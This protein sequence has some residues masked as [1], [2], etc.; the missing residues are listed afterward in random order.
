MSQGIAFDKKKV[1]KA[2]KPYFRLG[3]SLR[4]ACEYAGIAH[5]TVANWLMKDEELRTQITAWQN[6]INVLSR[7]KW[8]AAIKKGDA[9]KAVSWLERKERREFARVEGTVE[10][11]YEDFQEIKDE[12]EED[13]DEA[14]E[15]HKK[16]KEATIY[17]QKRKDKKICND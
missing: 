11:P 3:C 17:L 15:E 7:K 9:D 6:E 2:L 1:V 12:I 5:T 13:L 14:E 8:K 16:I 10:I 4:K